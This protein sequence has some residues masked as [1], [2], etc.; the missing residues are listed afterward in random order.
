M[1]NLNE[2]NL[3]E[4]SSLELRNFQGGIRETITYTDSKGYEW[5][6]TYDNDQ[7]VMVCVVQKM[8]IM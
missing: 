6:Y 7:L 3:T 2:M 8:T 5:S 1:K 4:L